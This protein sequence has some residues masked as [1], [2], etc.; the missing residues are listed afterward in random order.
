MTLKASPFP[1]R[2]V[3]ACRI[4]PNPGKR[5]TSVPLFSSNM[6]TRSKSNFLACRIENFMMGGV[7]FLQWIEKTQHF[8]NCRDKCI[9]PDR[10][11]A[12]GGYARL[13]AEIGCALVK[14]AVF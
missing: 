2:T 14:G 4:A 11:D 9:F 13:R 1:V 6:F 3:S 5:E 10:N 7:Y 8:L 12:T